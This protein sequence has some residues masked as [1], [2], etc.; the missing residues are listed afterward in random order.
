M[1]D[2]EYRNATAEDSSSSLWTYLTG[3]LR[4]SVQQIT[5]WQDRAESIEIEIWFADADA[6]N[7]A[8]LVDF[9]CFMYRWSEGV[10]AH[11]SGVLGALPPTRITPAEHKAPLFEILDA[12]SGSQLRVRLRSV[13]A[14]GNAALAVLANLFGV[15]NGA[16]DVTDRF[17]DRD[18]TTKVVIVQTDGSEE[19]KQL[20][21]PTGPAA[22]AAHAICGSPDRFVNIQG[23]VRMPDGAVVTFSGQ[24]PA[25]SSGTEQ[26]HME[27][28]ENVFR[29]S[30]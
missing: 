25:H 22:E 14:G 13:A 28:V 16:F 5:G 2:V 18:R 20:P 15:F 7:V 30:E 6:E 4:D 23:I 24:F 19:A 29:G 1:S 21:N 26:H 8:R 27:Q 17:G 12:T 3:P 10:E 11:V 9:F